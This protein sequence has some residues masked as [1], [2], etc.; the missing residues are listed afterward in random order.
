M[1]ELYDFLI[2]FIR[3]LLKV[4]YYGTSLHTIESNNGYY[5]K[6]TQTTCEVIDQTFKN[7]VLI[8]LNTRAI[9]S[10]I[11]RNTI[12]TSRHAYIIPTINITKKFTKIEKDFHFNE[13][14]T[15]HIPTYDH[16]QFAFEV[17]NLL[18]EYNDPDSPDYHYR[19][20]TIH[21]KFIDIEKLKN[22]EIPNNGI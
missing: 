22:T 4:R 19:T 1:N 2:P 20:I 3:S 18:Y 21:P 7:R 17:R 16:I 5:I 11:F 8:E 12:S 15:K 9:E 13:S 10:R 14:L 6:L